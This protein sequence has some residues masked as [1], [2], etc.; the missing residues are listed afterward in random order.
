MHRFRQKVTSKHQHPNPS[1]KL[2]LTALLSERQWATIDLLLAYSASDSSSL[3]IEDPS[4]PHAVTSEVIV[5]F[6][7]RFQAPLRIIALLSGMYPESLSSIDPVGRYPIHVAS[8]WGAP[9]DVVKFLIESNPSAAGAPDSSGKTPLHYVAEHYAANYAS[10][11]KNQSVAALV[12]NSI[13]LSF[14][15][16]EA[17]LYVVKMLKAGA[18]KSVN[19][20]DD[21]GMNA[22]EY[23]LESDAH[24]EVIKAMQRACRDDWQER[25]WAGAPLTLVGTE[26]AAAVARSQSELGRRRHRDLVKDIQLKVTATQ[27]RN[28][29]RNSI[30]Q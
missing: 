26:A 1:Q 23:A 16:D 27:H 29:R 11:C 20:E 8:K 10:L 3:P 24:F 9:P 30:V 22:I 15:Q 5:H 12:P 21:E 18:P 4:L 7:A 28:T 25:S 6:A 14:N 13:T 17:M 19:L 2:T